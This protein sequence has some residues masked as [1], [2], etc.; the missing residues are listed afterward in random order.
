M[1][2]PAPYTPD[3]VTD[4]VT[5]TVTASV[6]AYD[7]VSG[8]YYDK[9]N[10]KNPIARWLMDGFFGAFDALVA[11]T[12]AGEA[13]E[14]GCGEGH[15]TLRMNRAGLAANGIDL[16]PD[17]IAEARANARAAGV[18]A[19]FEV[20]DLYALDSVA[21]RAPLIVSCEVLEHVPEPDR[22]LAKLASLADPWLLVS[23]PN[24]PLWRALNIA[25]GKYLADFGNTPGHI[26]HWSANGFDKLVRRHAHVI[27]VRQPLPWTM[28]L[29]RTD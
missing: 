5:D 6:P 10:T 1:T 19:R 3:S 28:I 29:A 9:Y 7:N 20:E 17:A 4:R 22:A 12:G 14:V 27:E 18:H 13:F 8:N 25:R 26:Q 15:L 23:V 2:A 11:E 21:R 24:E 16:E